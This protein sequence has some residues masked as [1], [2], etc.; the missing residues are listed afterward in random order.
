MTLEEKL[1]KL[2]KIQDEI[3][4]INTALAPN[5]GTQF[6]RLKQQRATLIDSIVRCY[7]GQENS[8]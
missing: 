2:C 4:Y 5:E 1:W 8:T 6:A 7:Q 3:T